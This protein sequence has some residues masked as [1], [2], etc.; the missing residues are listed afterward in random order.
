V[1]RQFNN[2]VS[3]GL[4]GQWKIPY[5]K[6]SMYD[7]IRHT[8]NLANQMQLG[9][10]FFHGVETTLNSGFTTMSTGLKQIFNEGKLLK[11]TANLIHGS[12]FIGPAIED[13]WNG[14]KGL[15]N[16]R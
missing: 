8:N 2:F 6:L 12:T 15:I 4:K 13:M 1:A 11:G 9:L 5:T 16:F 3:T 7:A 14:Q 10:S